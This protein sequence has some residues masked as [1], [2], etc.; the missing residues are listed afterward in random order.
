MGFWHQTIEEKEGKVLALIARQETKKEQLIRTLVEE[1]KAIHREIA[2]EVALQRSDA[3]SRTNAVRTKHTRRS[4][5]MLRT[6][7]TTL[8]A[9]VALVKKEIREEGLE[10]R[11]EKLE[12]RRRSA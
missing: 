8:T 5:S 9:L 6:Q 2:Q 3:R 10:Y 11:F 7:L 1:E 4:Q 12:N